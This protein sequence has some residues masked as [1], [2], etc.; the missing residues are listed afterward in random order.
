[1]VFLQLWIG[2]TLLFLS[3][4]PEKKTRYLY[5]IWVPSALLIGSFISSWFEKKWQ[6]FDKAVLAT[7]VA[8]LGLL[9][10]TAVIRL[11]LYGV[12]KGQ[13]SLPLFSCY[14]LFFIS[15][16]AGSWW[17]FRK[18][19]IQGIVAATLLL[20][21]GL[22]VFFIPQALKNSP[23]KQDYSYLKILN[24]TPS[25]KDL[26]LYYVEN[27]QQPFTMKMVYFSGRP[28]HNYPRVFS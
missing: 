25:Y 14:S 27:N 11:Y 26:P 28:I 24:S 10:S 19:S 17:A 5:P 9:G 3:L 22:T 13:L 18:R 21:I 6:G 1:M 23:P 2:F 12:L 16:I 7:H 4:F 20:M 8:M 15:V